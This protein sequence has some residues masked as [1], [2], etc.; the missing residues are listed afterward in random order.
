MKI[1]ITMQVDDEV[2]DYEDGSG[3]TL[4]AYEELMAT[5][6]NFGD[7]IMIDRIG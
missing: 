4:E 5:L 2:A 6:M 3:L 1:Q 7:D